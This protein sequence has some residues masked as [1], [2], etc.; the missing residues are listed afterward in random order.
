MKD[1][2]LA[3]LVGPSLNFVWRGYAVGESRRGEGE[4]A[5]SDTHD[6]REEERVNER[7]V[8]RGGTNKSRASMP[9]LNFRHKFAS[10]TCS[11]QLTSGVETQ[12]FSNLDE[13]V[14]LAC[15]MSIL[16]ATG[17][18]FWSGMTVCITNGYESQTWRNVTYSSPG[19]HGRIFR[20]RAQQQD[21]IDRNIFYSSASAPTNV[22]SV[23]IR[24]AGYE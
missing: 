10:V 9:V 22:F 18:S 4:E 3:A 15:P 21:W 24:N 8:L 17:P 14:G 13:H 19:Q 7:W 2:R 1:I 23:M 6:D 12:S 16:L 5:G 20:L 11:P